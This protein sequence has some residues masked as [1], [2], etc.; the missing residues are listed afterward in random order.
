MKKFLRT[1]ARYLFVI[2]RWIIRKLP[3]PVYRLS[4]IGF[5][6]IGHCVMFKKRKI[7]MKSLR[8]AFGA[9]MDDAHI[10]KIAR[11]CFNNFGRGMIDLIY[12]IDR[13][14]LIKERVEIE[15]KHY[16]ENALKAG[17]GAIL[18]SA[19][20]GNFILMY[21]RFVVEGYKTNVIM[22]RARD[23]EWEKTISEIRYSLG[24][25]TIYALP[26]RKCIEQ[27]L[28]V[29]RNNEILFILLDQNFGGAGRVFVDFFGQKAAT[30]AG[31]VVFSNRT[32]AP[33]LPLFIIRQ[34]GDKHK[35]VINPPVHL[36]PGAGKDILT[37]N[38]AKITKIIEDYIRKY[39]HEWGGWMHNRWK[40]RTIEEQRIIDRM[41]EKFDYIA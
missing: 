35:I 24:L 26:Q 7:A 6:A 11:Q 33:I 13:P 41:R 8:T 18:L 32:G 22:R 16:L 15:G 27:S 34:K 40:S 29:L 38:V 21:L 9:D 36:E 3:Y 31:P 12:L 20:F 4:M 10:R 5:V 30:A 25:H 17:N 2:I 1:L 39:P 14:H 28:R 37:A 23:E 19:H